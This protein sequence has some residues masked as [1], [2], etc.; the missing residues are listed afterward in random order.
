MEEKNE[1]KFDEFHDQFITDWK[2]VRGLIEHEDELINQRTNW[3]LSTNAF[4]FAAFV[5]SLKEHETLTPLIPVAGMLISTC[6]MIAIRAATKQLA[7]A[8]AWWARRKQ[9]DPRNHLDDANDEKNL[10]HPQI[11]GF[12]EEGEFSHDFIISTLLPSLFSA[13]WAMIFANLFAP[14]WFVIITFLVI[15]ILYYFINRK[16]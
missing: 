4:L 8:E 7:R 2:R 6:I 12:R 16:T 5:I 1:V 10:R 14:L 9:S 15:F 11:A 13:T 3:L